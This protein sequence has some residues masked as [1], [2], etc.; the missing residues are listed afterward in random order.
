[1]DAVHDL[2]ALLDAALLPSDQADRAVLFIANSLGYPLARM[3]SVEY[4][5]MVCGMIFSRHHPGEQQLRERVS[6]PG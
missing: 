2:K 1:M 6:R 5:G 3:F 4:P